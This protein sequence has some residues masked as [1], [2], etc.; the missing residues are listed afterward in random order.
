MLSKNAIKRVLRKLISNS[1]SPSV[2]KAMS[3]LLS[4]QAT[5]LRESDDPDKLA[6]QTFDKASQNVAKVA[7][8]I[9]NFVGW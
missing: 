6:A 4:E 1:S 2:L 3:E 7:K 5:G 8:S 9:P